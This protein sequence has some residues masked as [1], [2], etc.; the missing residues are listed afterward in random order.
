MT[1]VLMVVPLSWL[2]DS[3][4]AKVVFLHHR[5][6]MP[7]KLSLVPNIVEYKGNNFEGY[8]GSFHVFLQHLWLMGLPWFYVIFFG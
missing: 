8:M 2:L 7:T 1:D 5:N 3:L 4:V 6:L